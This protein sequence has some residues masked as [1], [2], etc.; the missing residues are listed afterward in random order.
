[1]A[2]EP[3]GYADKLGNRYEGRWVA[4]QMLLLLSEQL[5]SITLESVGDDEAGVDLWV[6]RLDGTR[7]AQQ[8][9][10][11]NGT[12]FNWSLR[13]L[14]SRAV[15]S[16][17]KM[18]L[19]RDMSHRFAFVSST[20]ANQLR[21]LSRSASDSTGDAQTFYDHQILAGS[22][23]RKEAFTIF[24][25]CLGLSE[26]SPP[27]R[28]TAFNLL[29][30]S[31]FHLFSDD[32]EQREELKWMARQSVVGE[33]NTVLSLLANFAEENLRKTIISSDIRSHLKQL[34]FEPRALL[35]DER[36]EPKLEE[37]R[38]EFEESIG[39]HLAGGEFIARGE[40]D[41]LKASIKDDAADAVVLHGSAGHG[42]SGVLY[43]FCQYLNEIQTPYLAVRLDRKTPEDNP[44]AFGAKLGLPDSPVNSLCA[45]SANRHCVLILDQ[46]D[47]LRWTSAHA[48]EGI[49]VCKALLREVQAMRLLGRRVSVVF[50]CRTFDLEHDPQIKIWLKPSQSFKVEKVEVT[51]LPEN[52]V[53][54]FVGRFNVD[55]RRMTSRRRGLLRSVHNLALWAEVMESDNSSPE[56][57]SGSDLLRAFWR[58]LRQELEKA[59]FPSSE[60]QRLLDTIVSHMEKTASLTAPKRIVEPH[61]GL[62]TGLQTRNVIHV[63]R[64][65]ISFCHQSHLDF[66]IAS[67]AIESMETTETSIIDWLGDKSQQS[68]FRR[69]QLRQL[70]Y[71]LADENT[72]QLSHS[73]NLLISSDEVRF[74]IKQ[75]TIETLGQLRPGTEMRDFVISLLDRK[76]WRDHVFSDV[77][78]GNTEW[79]ETL[80]ED[81]RLLKMLLAE[82]SSEY[83]TAAWLFNSVANRI[84]RVV[85]SALEAATNAGVTDRLFNFLWS[86]DAESESDRVFQ[87]RLSTIPTAVNPPYV[88]WDK[89]SKDRPDRVIELLAAFLADWSLDR[90]RTRAG[91]RLTV[92]HGND[93]KAIRSAARRVPKLA[94]R[95]LTPILVT[96]A[97]RR[98]KEQRAWRTR[99]EGDDVSYPN[100]KIPKILLTTLGAAFVALAKRHSSRFID[101]SS[102]IEKLRSRSVQALLLGGWSSLPYETFADQAVEWLLADTNRLRCGSER[103][104]PRW[105]EPA[106]L[107]R[108]MSSHC[109]TEVFQRLEETLQRY[110]DPDEKR[111]ASWWLKNA[112]E[113]YYRNGFGAARHFLL[114]AL[115]PSRRSSETTSRIGVLHEKFADYPKDH[116]LRSGS[117]GG[118]VRSPLG[119]DAIGRMSDKHWL[120]LIKNQKIPARDGAF[121]KYEKN[122]V[123]EASVEMFARDFGI[124]AK[125]EPERF[126]KLALRLPADAPA[127]YLAEVFSALQEE[128]PPNEVAEKDRDA[129][130][131]ASRELIDR[132]LDSVDLADDNYLM[133]QF[134]WLVLNRTD[135]DPSD[136]VVSRLVD[137]TKFS[138]PHYDV[139]NQ[140][141]PSGESNRERVHHFET[142]ALNHVRALA[143]SAIGSILFEHKH[144]LPRFQSAL[145]PILR[146][147]HPA[148]RLALV[149]VCLPIWNFNRPLAVDWFIQ[150]STADFWPACGRNA[151]RLMNCAFPEFTEQ[152]TPMIE[153]MVSSPEPSI[154]EEGAQ[155]ATARWLFFDSFSN[156]VTVCRRGP[157]PQR[158]GVVKIA[159]QFAKD[160]KYAEKC[161]PILADMCNDPTEEIREVTARAFHDER[162][163][164]IPNV[165]A[166]MLEFIESEA[167]DDDPDSLCDALH[168]FSGSLTQFT[169]V[170][171]AA[172]KRAI[173]SQSNPSANPNR[174]M[175]LLD[176]HLSG[177]ILRLYEQSGS[178]SLARIRDECLDAIDEMLE[179]RIAPARSLLEKISK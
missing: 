8:C 117:R 148:V 110:R 142:V 113:G 80:H 72:A 90:E 53:Q 143:V 31:D 124:A 45:V 44:I 64:R 158:I 63:D 82:E 133:R 9:K 119:K 150:A 144:L 149:G 24:C 61:E 147:P 57:D 96:F 95:K 115:D 42:K 78:H 68:L 20:P 84:P 30:R 50:S 47:A 165:S 48:T 145:E 29:S 87:F 118:S 112:S 69:E 15:L 12:K 75:L 58:N 137:L 27:D 49:D 67:R 105:C 18:Q 4:R 134:C 155:E 114:P 179:H 89:I 175:G 164:E 172:V 10:A 38:D 160:E 35:A 141:N 88:H 97:K 128:K 156:L 7:E 76:E 170:A 99:T 17:L 111:F 55:F 65:S 168:D 102:R 108:K 139:P 138:D 174:R 11:E 85:D 28:E 41:Q 59:G 1:M 16:H 2:F 21:D 71:L 22:K 152:L 60:I 127:E 83:E 37:L 107:V 101:L 39:P 14:A 122:S 178:R 132:V 167:F 23:D 6:T 94:V 161:F 157:S 98:I 13:D 92:D 79:I 146:D 121:R 54:E 104:R 171:F 163:L 109:S 77:I 140:M 26:S 46:L 173:E 131:P 81:G 151:Q 125:R 62:A 166:F 177:V 32:R 52:S 126:G 56:F 43:Q 73:I 66:L 34:G 159:A 5:T 19:Q 106:R 51:D 169:D 70:L 116:F 93:I 130:R 91:R 36:I 40:V 162:L 25:D 120:Q 153:S 74:H 103:R 154:A 123:T 176:R 135:L 33:S 3:G 86:S 136:R 129:W 100:T